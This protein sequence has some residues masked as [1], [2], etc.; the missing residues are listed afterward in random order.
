MDMFDSKLLNYQRLNSKANV[1]TQ[2]WDGGC[3]LWGAWFKNQWLKG[4]HC[5]M[6][7]SRWRYR[8][9][10]IHHLWTNSW[11]SGFPIRFCLKIGY[12]LKI[13][14]WSWFSLW[15]WPPCWFTQKVATSDSQYWRSISFELHCSHYKLTLDGY[16][17]PTGILKTIEG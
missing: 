10:F 9:F 8:I 5:P 16:I 1:E 6:A 7:K 12:P 3:C 15:K 11:F 13:P 14:R 4:H 17:N 2:F